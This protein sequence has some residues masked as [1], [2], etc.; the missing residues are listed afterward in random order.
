MILVSKPLP[1]ASAKTS[2]MSSESPFFSS[3]SRSIRSMK[4][5]S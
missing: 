2:R 3:S 1:L 4:D 5:R